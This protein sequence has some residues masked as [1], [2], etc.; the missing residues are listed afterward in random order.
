MGICPGIAKQSFICKKHAMCRNICSC[1]EWFSFVNTSRMFLSPVRTTARFLP[2]S[3]QIAMD[4]TDD[5]TV[6][7]ME[8]RLEAEAKKKK[9]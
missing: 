8:K 5:E 1:I 9:K 2:G 4:K 6:E 3:P 7:E